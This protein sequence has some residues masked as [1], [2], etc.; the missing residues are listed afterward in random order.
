MLAENYR[1]IRVSILILRLQG[2][3]FQL[4]VKKI[5]DAED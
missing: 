1:T 5:A 4:E 3:A 2:S